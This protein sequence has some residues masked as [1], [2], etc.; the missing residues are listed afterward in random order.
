MGTL[1]HFAS[2]KNKKQPLVNEFSCEDNKMLNSKVLKTN[3][4]PAADFL[5]VIRQ[6]VKQNKSHPMCNITT[7]ESTELPQ[8]KITH[9]L[10]NRIKKSSSI[11]IGIKIKLKNRRPSEKKEAMVKRKAKQIMKQLMWEEL[12]FKNAAAICIHDGTK[13]ATNK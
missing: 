13:I 3:W 8:P 6:F 5:I 11:V 1:L 10:I 12:N 9:K 2:F 7:A 4:Y